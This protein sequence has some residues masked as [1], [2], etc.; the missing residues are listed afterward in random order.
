MG[1]IKFKVNGVEYCVSECDVSSNTTLLDYVRL[2]IGLHGTKYMCREGGC[3]ACIVTVQRP[4]GKPYAVNACM[5][6]VTSCHGLEITTI[7]GLGNRQKGYHELQTT[8]ANEHGSQ[9]GYCS[10]AWVMAMYGL[11]Q[12]NPD[13]T[14]LE[15]EKSLSSNICRCTGY[16]P[17]MDAFKKFAKDAPRQIKLQDIEDLKICKKTGEACDTSNCEDS[18]WC[19]VEQENGKSRI[20]EIKLNDNRLWVRVA[21]VKD[22]FKILERE[23]DDS[24][25]LVCGNT[26]RGVYPIDEYP[27][28][29]IDIS[30]VLELKGYETDQ[31]LI[32]NAGTTLTEFLKILEIVANEDDFKYL[33]QIYEHMLNVAHIPVRNVASIAGNLMIKNKHHWFPSDIFLLLELIGAQVTIQNRS[34]G[35]RTLTMQQFLHTNMRAT[36]IL[37]VMLPPLCKEDHV[38]TFKVMPRSQ[39]AIAIINAGFLYKLGPNNVVKDARIVFGALSPTFSRACSTEQFLKGKNLFTNLTLTSALKILEEELV[40]KE[41]PPAPSVEYR[42][43]TALGLFYKGLLKLSPETNLHARYRSGAT[44]LSDVRPVS[45]AVQVFETNQT[46]W[47][48]TQPIPRREAL[49]QCAGEASYTE[50][51]PLHPDEVFCAFAV[52]TIAKGDIV[53]IDASE[54]LAYP[55]VIAFY[56]AK[57]IPGINSYTPPDSIIYTTNEEVLASTSVNYFNQAIGIIVAK[58]RHIA[59]RAAKLVKATYTNIKDPVLELKDVI[60]DQA[61]TSPFIALDATDTGTDVTK[62]INGMNSIKGQYTFMLET[63][64][65][66]VRPSDDGFDV[67]SAS[68]WMEGVQLMI[69][70]A[71]G[72]D[73]NRVDV[74]T[75]L[76]GGAYGIKLSRGIQGAIAASLVVQK[77]NVPCRIVQSLTS[78]TRIVGKR[79]P[80]I[81]EFEAGVNNSGTIQYI[82]YSIYEDAGYMINGN[83]INFISIG[84]YNNAYNRSRWSYKSFNSVTDSAKNTWVRAPGTLEHIAMAEFVMEQISYEMDL[85]PLNVRLANLDEAYASEMKEMLDNVIIK[86]DYVKRR[87]LVSKFNA[88]NRWKKRGLRFAFL[89]WTPIGAHN[90]YVNISVYR[91]DGSVA[92]THGGIEMGQGINTKAA[93]VAAY[94]LNIPI[95]K[96]VVKGNDTVIAPNASISGG[97][98]VNQGVILGVSR[99]CR[100][101]LD[102]LRP[103]REQMDNPTWE[104]LIKK[105]HLD[106]V[107]LQAHGFTRTDEEY[108]FVVY[109]VILAEVE[110]DVLTGQFELL[111]VDLCE[112]VGQ[113]VSPEIDIGQVE[114]AFIMGLGYWTCENLVYAP[115]GELLTDRTW[116]YHPPL[117]RDI[118][119]DWRVYFRKNSYSSDDIFGSKCIGEPPICMAVVVAL[120]LREAITAARV[121]SGIP[122]TQWF[123]ED[124]PYTVERNALLCST[125][126]V[127]FKFN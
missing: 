41:N 94:L 54:A 87:E 32:V 66:V 74:H 11:L 35:K 22:I 3:G 70:R 96:I 55:G 46:V 108:N 107:D 100:Q 67:Y 105:A 39:N 109:G 79:L 21:E 76:V 52:S 38:I 99:A 13:I 45:R 30:G 103:I 83:L 60:H 23:G 102:R 10:P 69:S 20:I 47:P 81:T 64:T 16:R 34:S 43:K 57:D 118:P 104:E 51:R 65:T 28:V 75:R 77:L 110:L 59:D 36:V 61:R 121:D 97:S 6:P 15:V 112:D 126:T 88:D 95:D 72:I 124:R 42:K 1:V 122:K 91:G 73:Q 56:T 53:S 24:Y 33:K 98:I 120:A 119:Q 12:G 89:R 106:N 44:V 62:V 18:D 50:D 19:I 25:M 49:I 78:N 80:C 31:N 63:L 5:M 17:I 93:Q 111:R 2:C 48:V 26:A 58:D 101:L 68:Q 27:R 84:Q 9:C 37:N 115:T 92:I 14:M 29:L 117:A 7:E 8:L 125:N 4:P 123:P 86:S 90:F 116:N 127:E 82:N 113:S 114:G 40:I 85:D 71:L